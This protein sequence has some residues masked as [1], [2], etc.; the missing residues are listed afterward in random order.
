MIK[1]IVATAVGI[2]SY[3]VAMKFGEWCGISVIMLSV[4]V[5]KELF[6]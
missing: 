4:A 5:Y 3:L 1:T 2:I 6:N